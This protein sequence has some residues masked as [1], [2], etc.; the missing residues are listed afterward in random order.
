[1]AR[2]PSDGG[3]GFLI[4]GFAQKMFELRS[5]NTAKFN[6]C[7]PAQLL[8]GRNWEIRI[9]SKVLPNSVEFGS[10]SSRL[11]HGF[12]LIDKFYLKICQIK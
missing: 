10:E 1:V 6:N 7:A 8:S 12:Q 4:G 3:A 9:R 11:R 5:K 2:F